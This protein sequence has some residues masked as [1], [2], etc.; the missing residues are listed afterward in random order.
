MSEAFIGNIFFEREGSTPGQYDRVC[1]VFSITGVG[2]A[3]ALE[4]VTTFCSGG[5]REYIGGLADGEEMSI[6]SNYGTSNSLSRLMIND[7]KAKTN[8]NYRL[9]IE[10]GS[11]TTIMSFA[12]TP[13]SWV[14]NPSVDSKNT[15]SFTVKISGEVTI[16]P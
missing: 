7:V 11:P 13:L 4:D 9:V 10:D 8:K 2:E 14:L 15:I 1:E 6:E 16:S 12:G 3:N 5:F